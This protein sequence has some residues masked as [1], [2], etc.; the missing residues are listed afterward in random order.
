[1]TLE[2]YVSFL[3]CIDACSSYSTCAYVQYDRNAEEC[4]LLS[5]INGGQAESVVDVAHVVST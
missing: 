3:Q 5:A 4:F 1:V 2:L